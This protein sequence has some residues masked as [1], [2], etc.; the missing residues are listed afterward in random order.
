MHDDFVVVARGFPGAYDARGN[1]TLDLVHAVLKRLGCHVV[2]NR[3]LHPQTLAPVHGPWQ[4]LAAHVAFLRTPPHGYVG[5]I[6]ALPGHYVALK[7]LKSG[8]YLLIDSLQ[9][10]TERVLDLSARL[11]HARSLLHVTNESSE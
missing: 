2:D 7:R 3:T 10:T 1:Y 8:E 9:T 6:V 4:G 11:A 5:C